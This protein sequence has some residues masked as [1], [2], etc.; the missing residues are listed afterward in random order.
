MLERFSARGNFDLIHFHIDYLHFPVAGGNSCPTSP[1]CTAGSIFPIW[2]RFIAHIRRCRWFPFR[3]RSGNRYPG[4]TGKEP[5]IT[6]SEN[7]KFY[8]TGKVPGIPGPHFAGERLDRAIE[9]AK[10]TGMP[11]KIAA[12]IDRA[13]RNI[14]N[15][16]QALLDH[17]LI[18][19][20][21][22]IGYAEKNDFL[23][24]AS[25]LLFPIQWPEPFGLV[26]IEAMACGTPVI[27]YPA[28]PCRDHKG[29]SHRIYRRDVRTRQ[30]RR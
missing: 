4:Q 11:L 1:H 3:M 14:L 16:D 29:W 8:R 24:N 28:A 6:D 23:G 15:R 25:A 22:E 9:I 10:R 2:F 12:K 30:S 13:D 19:F 17:P 21:G 18:E 26:M 5:C 27:A 20:I 7:F